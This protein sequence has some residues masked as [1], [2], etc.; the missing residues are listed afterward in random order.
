MEVHKN[1][2]TFVNV[3][4]KK[5]DHFFATPYAS[6]YFLETSISSF[7]LSKALLVPW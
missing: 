6:Y 5:D 4:F 3:F 7:S 2:D 1:S